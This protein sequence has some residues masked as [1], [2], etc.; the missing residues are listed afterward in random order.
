MW[1]TRSI[2]S[3][4]SSQYRFAASED[5]PP[6]RHAVA[7]VTPRN[8]AARKSKK[9]GDKPKSVPGAVYKLGQ[10]RLLCGDVLD[11]DALKRLFGKTKATACITDPPYNVAYSRKDENADFENDDLSIKDWESFL[12]DVCTV[13]LDRTEGRCYIFMS[14]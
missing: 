9:K 11:T 5:F 12:F 14:A 7:M 10:H 3:I 8:P 2:M 6:L 13:L 4:A 1:Q